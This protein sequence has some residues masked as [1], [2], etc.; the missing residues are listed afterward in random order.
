MSSLRKTLVLTENTF[1]Y[2]KENEKKTGVSLSQFI[3]S[4]YK[5]D[6]IE[7]VEDTLNKN[8]LSNGFS[9]NFQQILNYSTERNFNL[10]L[11]TF[12]EEDISSMSE[13]KLI[14]SISKMKNDFKND[15]GFIEVV[16]NLYKILLDKADKIIENNNEYI[17][18]IID[19]DNFDFY[20][21]LIDVIDYE[22]KNKNAIQKSV[23]V[24]LDEETISKIKQFTL[25][26]DQVKEIK[27]AYI[28]YESLEVILRS[29]IENDMFNGK[30]QNTVLTALNNLKENIKPVFDIEDKQNKRSNFNLNE[31]F[32][33]KERIKTL[34]IKNSTIKR[35]D[36]NEEI[37]EV[38]KTYNDDINT[39]MRNINTKK[40]ENADVSNDVL[41]LTISIFNDCKKIRKLIK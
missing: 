20:K 3:K 40:K 39:A 24:V 19:N 41:K 23:K 28:Q 4:I 27:K 37:K 7:I 1:N 16:V 5:D 29:Y 14:R 9:S 36:K 33:L 13:T 17:S 12:I 26:L 8:V 10:N 11:D 15:A 21:D 32:L 18:T 25:D 34:K 31:L 38:I 35:S 30:G 2:F 22:L 6:V